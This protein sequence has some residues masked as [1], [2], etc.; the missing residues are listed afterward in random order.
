MFYAD[1]LK[2]FQKT[3]IE[4]KNHFN[5]NCGNISMTDSTYFPKRG[6][7]YAILLEMFEFV[8]LSTKRKFIILNEIIHNE[9]NF[10][11]LLANVSLSSSLV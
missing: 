5:E 1:E 9:V 3:E 8:P 10:S 7:D 2:K 6:F 4:M 11:D